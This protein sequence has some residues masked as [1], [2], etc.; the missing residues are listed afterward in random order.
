M[1][2]PSNSS[3][4]TCVHRY[5]DQAKWQEGVFPESSIMMLGYK[6]QYTIVV[7]ELDLVIVRLGNGWKSTEHKRAFF[8]KLFAFFQ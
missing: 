7:P 3:F 1:P 4:S 8:Q 5:I 6:D 2:K